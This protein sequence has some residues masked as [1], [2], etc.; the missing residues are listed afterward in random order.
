MRHER[1]GNPFEGYL[2]LEIKMIIRCHFA[3]DT[4]ECAQDDDGVL[5]ETAKGARRDDGA[6]D[7]RTLAAATVEGVATSDTTHCLC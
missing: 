2:L 1:L 4:T 7:C 3:F 5:S 6:S